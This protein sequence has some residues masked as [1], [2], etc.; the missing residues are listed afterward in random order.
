MKL[1]PNMLKTL[2]NLERGRTTVFGYTVG[3][4]GPTYL[5]RHSVK[6]LIKRGLLEPCGEMP[7]QTYMDGGDQRGHYVPVYCISEAG[8]LALKGEG[9]QPV[10]SLKI[11]DAQRA[12]LQAMAE[13]WSLHSEYE[14]EQGETRLGNS[15]SLWPEHFSFHSRYKSVLP[16]TLQALLRLSLVEEERRYMSGNPMQGD[17]QWER[18]T[19]VYRLSEKGKEVIKGGR[20]YLCGKEAE[21]QCPDCGKWTCYEHRRDFPP[22]FDDHLCYPC[23]GKHNKALLEK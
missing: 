3:T 4:L 18:W 13:N 22:D 20:C 15:P 17:R 12:V 9:E 2:Q 11:S 14:I 7:W 10:Q 6:A 21:S 23:V 16:S 5:N 1:S 19:I 8:K